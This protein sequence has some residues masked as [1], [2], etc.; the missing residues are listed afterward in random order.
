MT[1]DV[2]IGVLVMQAKYDKVWKKNK[3]G[4]VVQAYADLPNVTDDLEESLKALRFIGVD[5]FGPD[6]SYILNK[7]LDD[8]DKSITFRMY[9]DNMNHAIDKRL[10]KDPDKMHLVFQPVAGHGMIFE[11]TQWL[12]L[13]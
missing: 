7:D 12:L 6:D 2:K 10:K 4:E 3:D 1:P 9:M 11:G 5:D 8:T 13:N